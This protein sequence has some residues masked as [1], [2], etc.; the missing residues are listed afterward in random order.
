MVMKTESGPF[1]G[2]L[3]KAPG[4]PPHFVK[5]DWSKYKDEDDEEKE[6]GAKWPS[7]R[8]AQRD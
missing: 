7:L 3:L 5:V 6:S 8:V 1:W 4:K 2:R